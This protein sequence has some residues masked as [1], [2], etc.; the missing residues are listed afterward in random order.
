MKKSELKKINPKDFNKKIKELKK[1][2][3]SNRITVDAKD[4]RF[5]KKMTRKAIAR[6][7]TVQNMKPATNKPKETPE[8]SKKSK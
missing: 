2:C 5:N 8:L 4:S 1:D 7:K 3:C 6:I